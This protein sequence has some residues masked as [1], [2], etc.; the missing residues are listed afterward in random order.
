MLRILNVGCK[1]LWTKRN[2]KGY[3]LETPANFSLD[4]LRSARAIFDRRIII[5]CS[6]HVMRRI[7]PLGWRISIENSWGAL[8]KI[9]QTRRY[10]NMLLE[11]ES[12]CHLA[13]SFLKSR[14]THQNSLHTYQHTLCWYCMRFRGICH[15]ACHQFL[16]YR[17]TG[18]WSRYKR[19]CYRTTCWEAHSH[20][21]KHKG[22]RGRKETR[23]RRRTAVDINANKTM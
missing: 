22:G 11:L 3:I 4:N 21:L 14:Q 6:F 17:C 13:G 18:R 7:R 10:M 16:V 1:L 8:T 19:Y 12:G 2:L 15:T 20:S 9:S 23:V 5:S